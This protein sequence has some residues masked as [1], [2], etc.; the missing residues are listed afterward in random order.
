[1]RLY[2]LGSAYNVA[3]SEDDIYRFNRRWPASELQG[4]RGV[5]FQFEKRN[6]A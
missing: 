4:L 2:D 1:M 6:G 5:T 3:V